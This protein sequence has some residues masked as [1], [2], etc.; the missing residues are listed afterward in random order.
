MIKLCPLL[1]GGG[2]ALGL[3]SSCCPDH[4]AGDRDQEDECSH[5]GTLEAGSDIWIWPDWLESGTAT[6]GQG[7]CG[8]DLVAEVALIGG[9]EIPMTSVVW[10]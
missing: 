3:L 6:N 2:V 7:G 8:R 5:G 4:H 9:T 1:C 10:S